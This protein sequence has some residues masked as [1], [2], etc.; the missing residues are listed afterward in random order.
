MT[1]VRVLDAG[2]GDAPLRPDRTVIG[3]ATFAAS[4]GEMLYIFAS[5]GAG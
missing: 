1:G 2:G 5:F 4:A 3:L